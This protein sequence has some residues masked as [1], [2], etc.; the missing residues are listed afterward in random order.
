MADSV[1][2]GTASAEIV[3]QNLNRHL[4][5]LVEE[6]RNSRKRAI[7]GITKETILRKPALEPLVIQEVFDEI[8]KS[9]L[10]IFADPV[11]KNRELVIALIGKCLDI[12]P[13]P[14]LFLPF[15]VPTLA[16]RLGQQEMVESSEEVRLV[17]VEML[18]KIID[19]SGKKIAAYLDDLIN[20]LQKTI[21][22]PYPEVKKESCRCASALA[23]SI[24]EHFHMQSET[25]IK[26]LL[27]II[28][29]QHSKV[30]LHSVETIG[31]RFIY[32]RLV[33]EHLYV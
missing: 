7:E 31:K 9:L 3:L 15:L 8:L 24:P 26:P 12:V 14:H 16:Q 11:E 32:W 33:L 2:T 13:Q 10:K 30:R 28:S 20:V 23:K 18:S 17:L 27:L 21:V 29:H 5:C 6:N 1:D 19:L 22:D 25:L 4:N